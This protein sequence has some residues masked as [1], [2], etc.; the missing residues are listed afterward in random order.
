ML[1]LAC[2]AF[3]APVPSRS[4]WI[5]SPDLAQND[6]P[7]RS[8]E[9]TVLVLENVAQTTFK[10]NYFNARDSAIREAILNFPFDTGMAV[11]HVRLEMPN[12][13]FLSEA[14]EP[15]VAEA[16]YEE[17]KATGH[18]ALLVRK[19]GDCLAINLAVIPPKTEMT[20]WLAVS[21]VMPT[22]FDPRR[23]RWYSHYVLP[24]TFVERY[25]PANIDLSQI[26]SPES[27]GSESRFAFSFDMH[28][29]FAE[30]VSSFS[31]P[32][33]KVTDPHKL[34]FRGRITKDL[35][36]DILHKSFPNPIVEVEGQSQVTQFAINSMNFP[37]LTREPPSNPSIVFVLDRSGSMTGEPI[38]CLRNAISVFLHSLPTTCRFDLIGFGSAFHPLFGE[39]VTY[40]DEH[41]AEAAL[42]VSEIDADMDGTEMVAPLRHVLGTL[43][44]DIMFLLT[45][46]ARGR[47]SDFNARDRKRRVR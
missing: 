31:Y 46:G 38:Q 22:M 47:Y 13:T 15:S 35:I 32:H 28:A 36:V 3:A 40:D 23:E 44:P 1:F 37:I 10:L 12:R 30:A 18:T 25:S 33:A 9:L 14:F 42:Y 5:E 24:I 41:L 39:L 4:V 27:S 7:L 45:D 17:Q 6:I 21:S 19:A 8:M 11:S 20:V 34:W 29:P 43:K 26:T 16:A 2:A